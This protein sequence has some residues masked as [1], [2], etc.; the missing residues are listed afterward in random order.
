[1]E[2]ITFNS[3][4]GEVSLNGEQMQGVKSIQIKMDLRKD[5]K[6]RMLWQK[7]RPSMKSFVS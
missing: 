1:M 7:P 5:E 2:K 4:T 3:R 6:A